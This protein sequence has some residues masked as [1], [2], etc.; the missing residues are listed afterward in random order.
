MKISK[1]ILGLVA[2]LSLSSLAGGTAYATTWYVRDGGGNPSQCTG[3]TDAVYPGNGTNQPCALANPMYVLGAGCGNTGWNTC[4]VAPRMGNG[5][6]LNI[7]GDSDITPGAQAQYPIGLDTSGVIT[8]T[9]SSNCYAPSPENCTMANIPSNSSIIGKGTHKPQLWGREQVAQILNDNNSTSTTI[10]NLEITQHSACVYNGSD[11][12]GSTDGFP[13]RCHAPSQGFSSPYGNWGITGISLSGSGITLQNNWIHG[14]GQWGVTTGSLSDFSEQNN[15]INGNGGGGVGLGQNN[16]GGSISLGGTTSVSNEIIVFNGCGSRYPLHSSDPFDTLN[17]HHCADDNSSN[18]GMLAD[19]WAIES[20]SANCNNVVMNNV[21]VAFNTKGG[22]DNL[23]CTGS[24][25][26][27]AY[28]VRAEGNESQ[29][30]KLNYGSANI[31]NSQIINDC[32]YFKGQPFTTSCGGDGSCPPDQGY[33][34]C[35]AS[36]NGI[37]LATVN[38]GVYNLVNNTFFSDGGA[39]IELPPDTCNSSTVVH[40]LNNLVIGASDLMSGN[41]QNAGFWENDS[42]TCNPI[43]EDYNLVYQVNDPFHC[44]GSHDICDNP[45]NAGVT[46]NFALNGSNTYSGIDLAD[47]FYP[48]AGS[49]LIGAANSSITLT[50]TS[51]DY[52]NFSRG[53]SWDIGSYEHG[54]AVAG[55]GVC[56]SSGECFSG[57]CSSNLCMGAGSVPTVEITFP[58]SGST[59]TPGSG[60]TLSATASE[61]NGTIARVKF[62]NGT[63]ALNYTGTSGPYNYTWNNVQQG[64]YTLTAQATDANG[65]TAVSSPVTIFVTN[66]VLPSLPVVTVTSPANGSAF[67]AGSNVPISVSASEANGT[68]SNISLYNGFGTLLGTSNGSPYNFIDTNVAAGTYI[69]YAVATDANG[70]STTSSQITIT[71]TGPTQPAPP[72]PPPAGPSVA[73]TSPSN[74]AALNG[75][76]SVNLSATAS[77][78]NGTIAKV[79]FFN[80]TTALSYAGTSSPYNYTWNNVQPG[81]YTLTAQATDANGMTATSSPVT[82]TVSAGNPIPPI[83]PTVVLTSPLN[84][85]TFTGPASINLSA[86]A[87]EANGTITNVK[88]FNGT[89]ALS[90]TGTISPYSYAWNNVQPGTYTLTAQATDA[91]GVTA[92]SS[93]VTITVNAQQAI[94]PVVAM[95]SPA[96]NAVFTVPASINL[97]ATASESNGTIA[98]VKFFNG[99][100]ALSYAG[101]SPPY[102]YTWNNVQPGTYNL[103]AQAT[104]ANGVIA[105]SS[106][107]IITV[108][109]MSPV[110]AMTSPADGAVLTSPASINLSAT[111]SETNGT[112]TTV[113]FFNGA[114]ALGFVGSS[115]PYNFTW[116]NVQPGTY[117]LTAQ[118]TDANGVITTSS[119]ITVTVNPPQPALPTVTMTSPSNNGVFSGPLN[120]DLSATASETNGTIN[121]VQF[122]NGTVPLNYI[123]TSPPY[124]YT[125]NNVQ[126]GTYILTAQATDADGVSTTSSPVTITVNSQQPASPSV[127]L[128]SPPNNDVFSGPLNINLSATASEANGTISKLQFFNGNVPLN[129]VGTVSPY[130]YTWKNVQPGTYTLTAQATDANGVTATSNPATIT[131]NSLPLVAITNPVNNSITLAGTDMIISANATETNGTITSVFF[132]NGTSLLGSS[133]A[134]PYSFT[135]TNPPPGT[136]ILTAMAVDEANNSTT[137]APV[138]VTVTPNTK[139]L[140]IR[141]GL[142]Q[143][144]ELKL[145]DPSE[146]S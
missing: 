59:F 62:F 35:R 60:I 140:F 2:A 31:E 114:S 131:I 100:T 51:N 105:T 25:T 89:T 49:P 41:S 46:G 68:I 108:S 139:L 20:S 79:K 6:T 138:I 26:F 118:A 136:Y 98:K 57:S 40:I 104:D 29:Q 76:G 67:T 63:T 97:S 115:P 74:N 27:S 122:F 21:I 91:N 143:Q 38:S 116:S 113:K 85:A 34:F 87:L 132:Y 58:G 142:Q 73:M 28:R 94:S 126:P 141:T 11:P 103:T 42:G 10:N 1:I 123:G 119:P 18:G 146:L 32:N 86:T 14:M 3:T 81:T 93:P 22:I 16:S 13:N 12:N 36:G 84:N 137:S 144:A 43:V 83:S 39:N 69:F 107:I 7:N 111:A 66:S 120:I 61:T 112:I 72:A 37:R 56:F 134:P 124:N 92:T 54:S 133:A 88:Y 5:D 127:T 24:G 99:T 65:V 96:N 48:S 129:Y 135:W 52:N 101:T 33:D 53:S 70:V 64:T 102:N 128:T 8:P 125:W 90:Y 44:A 17:Y 121:R 50:G 78:S 80:G 45:S 55:G 82:I 109:P 71:V 4:D 110:V 47:Q 145:R 30:M 95:T 9:H 23:H 106:P 130:N 19:G 117:S 15:T 77:E 75:P